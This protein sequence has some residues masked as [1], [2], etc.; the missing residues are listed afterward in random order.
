MDIMFNLAKKFVTPSIS[1]NAQKESRELIQL[2]VEI[3]RLVNKM[4]VIGYQDNRRIVVPFYRIIRFY[5]QGKHVVCETTTGTY[6]VRQRMYELRTQ[7]SDSMFI[8]VSN[9]EIVNKSAIQSFSL[10]N[11]GS[12]QINLTTGASTYTSRRYV[13]QIKEAFLK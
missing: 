11:S 6:R 8:S 1:I 3:D 4:T 12:Y 7:L 13:K 10:T 9:A 5:T 2:S